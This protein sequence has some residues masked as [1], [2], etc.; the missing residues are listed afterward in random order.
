MELARTTAGHDITPLRGSARRARDGQLA[1]LTSPGDYPVEAICL[2]CGQ[3]VRCERYYTFG[4]LGQA[5]WIHLGKFS[6]KETP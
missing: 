4:A 6:L 5:D 1:D 2:E 3:P